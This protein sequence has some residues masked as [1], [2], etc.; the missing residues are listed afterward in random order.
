[1]LGTGAP[2]HP[3]RA[4]TGILVQGEDL[5]PLLIDTCGG[6]EL[7]RQLALVKQPL[8]SIKHVILTHH[9]GDH[10][11]G[12]MA[13]ALARVPCTYYG[14]ADTLTAIQELIST[15]YGEYDIHPETQ[16][17]EIEATKTYV[18]AGYEV[19]FFEIKHRVPTVAIRIRVN[20]KVLA[21]S[22]DSLPCPALVECA[23]EADL[24]ICDAICASTD[25]DPARIK[26]LMH[27]T[28][29][30]AAQLA[31]EA[32]VRS[33]LLTHLARF[34]NPESMLTEAQIVYPGLVTISNDGDLFYV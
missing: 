13:L 32:H 17:K 20:N 25:Y 9:H 18:I 2:L 34:A 6:L 3:I 11:G 30:E 19:S 23:K 31:K 29:L 27:P 22:A 7:A 1:M 12:V 33:L 15:T 4:G 28:A 14:L 16:Y 21:F 8:D 24:F 26:F 10:M 5:E